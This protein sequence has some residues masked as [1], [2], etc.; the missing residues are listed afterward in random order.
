ML[1]GSDVEL[2]E[3]SVTLASDHELREVQTTHKGDED[4]ASVADE[5]EER[6]DLA[7][8]LELSLDLGRGRVVLIGARRDLG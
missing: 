8:V 4:H 2:Q 7:K 6:L 5:V 1:G 3:Q